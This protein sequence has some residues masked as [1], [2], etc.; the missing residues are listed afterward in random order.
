[1]PAKRSATCHPDR[2]SVSKGLCRPCWGKTR[3]PEQNRRSH[4]KKYRL[5]PQT[6][7]ALFKAQ[8]SGCCICGGTE[9]FKGGGVGNRTNLPVDHDH[10]TGWV[11]GILCYPC[12]TGL[13]MFKDNSALLR[14][15]AQYLEDNQR[16]CCVG[17]ARKHREHLKHAIVDGDYLSS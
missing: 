4:L 10:Q 8:G 15:A 7:D 1:M 13:G 14:A 3:T 17:A 6:Y 11:R 16:A 9:V 12:N 5:T 2:S